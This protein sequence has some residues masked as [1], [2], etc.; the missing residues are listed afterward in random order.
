MAPARR[1]IAHIH[2]SDQ[3]GHVTLSLADAA[4]VCTKGWG[5]RHRLSGTEWLHLGYTMLYVPRSMA[6][7]EVLGKILQAGVEY[8]TSGAGEE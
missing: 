1:E 6:E 8:M 2:A 5:E 7:V 4:E 3:S